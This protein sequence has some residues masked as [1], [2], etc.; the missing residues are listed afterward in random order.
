MR[1]AQV[2][3][4]ITTL[5]SWLTQVPIC[6]WPKCAVFMWH[7]C[8]RRLNENVTTRT[9]TK[10]KKKQ[11]KFPEMRKKSE[12]KTKCARNGRWRQSERESGHLMLVSTIFVQ[13]HFA[14]AII[15]TFLCENAR[16][17]F[18][19]VPLSSVHEC[20]NMFCFKHF[21]AV[22]TLPA[23][24]LWNKAELKRKKKTESVSYSFILVLWMMWW[25]LSLGMFHT[26]Y[27]LFEYASFAG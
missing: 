26:Q 21:W 17:I 11:W 18:F 6:H 27:L 5:M 3:I 20:M 7:R 15:S 13:V 4:T 10:Q 24:T 22:E 8:E 23:N 9:E 12:K 1:K 16:V 14:R 19:L 25:S 2:T